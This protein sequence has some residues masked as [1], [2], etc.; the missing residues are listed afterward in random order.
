M[1]DNWYGDVTIAAYD[2]ATRRLET[3]LYFYSLSGKVGGSGLGIAFRKKRSH[4]LRKKME[5][6]YVVCVRVPYSNQ[7][8]LYFYEAQPAIY[9]SNRFASKLEISVQSKFIRDTS[10]G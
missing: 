1:H 5:N 10:F 3:I 8:K 4:V 6:T 2:H 7:I 9:E